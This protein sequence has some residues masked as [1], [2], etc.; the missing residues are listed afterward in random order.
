MAKS[1]SAQIDEWVAKTKADIETVVKGSAF[2]VITEMQTP[3]ASGGNLRVDTR[4]LRSSLKVNLTGPVAIDTANP[5]KTPNSA[6]DWDDAGLKAAVASFGI[7][8]TLYATYAA[9]YAAIVHYKTGPQW[10]TLAAQ[11]WQ[12]IVNRNVAALK[13]STA[14]LAA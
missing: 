2:D 3:V 13:S 10:V 4:F 11:N 1:F 12:N 7:G 5:Y 14:S 8:D 9:E 6:P